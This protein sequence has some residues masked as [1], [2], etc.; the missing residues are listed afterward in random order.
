VVRHRVS[1]PHYTLAT[2]DIISKLGAG[3]YALDAFD[4][5]WRRVIREALRIRQRAKVR[6]VYRT[7]TSRRRDVV[8]F[9]EMAIA[10]AHWLYA[11]RG[12]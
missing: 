3:R 12:R 4:E 9:T 2:G 11:E 10:D 6:S 1:R 5:R 8:D 7:A